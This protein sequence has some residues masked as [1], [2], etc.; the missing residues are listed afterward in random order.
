MLTKLENRVINRKVF[1]TA[2]LFGLVFGCIDNLRVLFRILGL[3]PFRV[4]IYV[5]ILGVVRSILIP[6]LMFVVLY[7]LGKRI[8]LR[9]SY[10]SVS[11]SL[12]IG[13]AVGPIFGCF[14]DQLV[15]PELW[16]DSWVGQLYL[17]AVQALVQAS[18]LFFLGFTALA[19]A[20]L[21][22][23]EEAAEGVR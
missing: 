4:T 22:N 19:L 1:I 6:I 16:W 10:D 14:L 9:N 12:L 23:R 13:S 8:D 5:Y 15:Y 17:A 3:V 18:R 11:I 20:Y 7:R 21:R 2:L